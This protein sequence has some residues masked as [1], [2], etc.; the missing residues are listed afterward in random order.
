MKQLPKIDENGYFAGVT[1]VDES[2]REP[3]KYLL[4]KGVI[5]TNIPKVRKNK[6]AKWNGKK[7]VYENVRPP[8]PFSSW[9]F[10][11]DQWEWVPPK[12]KPQTDEAFWDEKNQKWVTVTEKLAKQVREE[13]N[14]LLLDTDWITLRSYSQGVTVPQKWKQYQQALRDVPQQQGFPHNV[15]WPVKPDS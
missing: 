4:P 5:D 6:I 12:Q 3:G 9:S 11:E 10:D 1:I 7:W 2:P 13:R 8:K 14:K 15:D